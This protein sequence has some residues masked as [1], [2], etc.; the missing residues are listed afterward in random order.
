MIAVIDIKGSWVTFELWERVQASRGDVA[1]VAHESFDGA[2][3]VKSLGREDFVADHFGVASDLLRDRLIKV[4][5][6][7][8]SYQAVIRALP[9]ALIISLLAVGAYL[10]GTGGCD[11]G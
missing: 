5:S 11:P 8:A 4:N 10:V 9:Q 2:L 3:T 6:T 1:S 7:W